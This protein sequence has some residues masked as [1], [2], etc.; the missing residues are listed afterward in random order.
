MNPISTLFALNPAAELRIETTAA[1]FP[2][3]YIENFYRDPDA[4]R[5][6]A[7][8]GKYD[9]SMAYYPGLHSRIAPDVLL[10]LQRAL[11]RILNSVGDFWCAPERIFSDFSVVTTPAKDMLATQKHPH[12]DHVPLAGVI[13]LNP[14]FEVGTSFFH[15]RALGFSVV[16]RPEQHQALGEWLD[17]NAEALQPTTYAIADDTIWQHLLTVSG[18][19]N[20]LVIYPGNVFHSIAMADVVRHTGIAGARLTQRFFIDLASAPDQMNHDANPPPA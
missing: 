5:R 15:N 16:S 6:E 4:V 19:Y 17:C 9:T 10:P 18:R 14:D 20:R 7:V 1:G 12:I 11:S 13:Y 8:G 3:L 2:V